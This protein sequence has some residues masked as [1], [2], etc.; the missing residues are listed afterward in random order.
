MND[1][2]V[3]RT[4]K[5]DLIFHGVLIFLGIGLITI[6]GAIKRRNSYLE[7]YPDEVI[8]KQGIISKK[9]L[10]YPINSIQAVSIEQGVLGKKFNYGTITITT[11]GSGSIKFNKMDNPSKIKEMIYKSK[12]M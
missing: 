1:V 9:E 12:A 8:A 11:A 10:S 4:S 6:W 7:I 5:V 2:Y 3:A